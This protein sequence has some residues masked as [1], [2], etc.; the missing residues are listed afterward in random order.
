MAG[1]A[2]SPEALLD[3]DDSGIDAA[4]AQMSGRLLHHLADRVATGQ[5]GEQA[6]LRLHFE[7]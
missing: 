2:L 4:L 5:S 3:G 6:T 1:L 7:H